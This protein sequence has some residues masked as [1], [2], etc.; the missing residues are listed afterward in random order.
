MEQRDKEKEGRKQGKKGRKK[1]HFGECST[2]FD[3]PGAR[4]SSMS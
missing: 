1:E 3:S 2:Q 4:A